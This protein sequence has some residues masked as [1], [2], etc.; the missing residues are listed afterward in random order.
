M[1]QID[2]NNQKIHLVSKRS[3]LFESHVLQHSY[4]LMLANQKTYSNHKKIPKYGS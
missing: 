4:Q 1:V 3:F 2:I